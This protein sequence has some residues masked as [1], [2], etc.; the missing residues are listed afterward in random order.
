MG[1]GGLLPTRFDAPADHFALQMAAA[2]AAAAV[3]AWAL[4]LLWAA[5]GLAGAGLGAASAL[6]WRRR[7]WRASVGWLLLA[8][9]QLTAGTLAAAGCLTLVFGRTFPVDLV[10]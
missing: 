7:P 4:P 1:L 9:V 5:V 2:V 10:G 8:A 6:G 3:G